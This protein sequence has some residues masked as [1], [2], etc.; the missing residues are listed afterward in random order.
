[1]DQCVI[2]FAKFPIGAR[3]RH[4]QYGFRGV[5]FDVDP[6]FSNTDEWYR[7]IPSDIRPAKNQPFYHLFAEHDD[8]SPYVAYV[9]EQNLV[10]DDSDVQQIDHPGIGATFEGLKDGR[11][12]MPQGRLH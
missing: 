12:V 3:V 1:M 9:S 5:V 4:R 7:S 10:G 2:G 6:V 8:Q 11:Y